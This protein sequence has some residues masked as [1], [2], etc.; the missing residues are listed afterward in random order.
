MALQTDI[1]FI[2]T[3]S[4]NLDPVMPKLRSEHSLYLPS[5]L[6]LLLIL[7]VLVAPVDVNV[8]YLR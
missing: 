7:E 5:F 3:V 2:P 8:Q 4:Q 6:G 1:W